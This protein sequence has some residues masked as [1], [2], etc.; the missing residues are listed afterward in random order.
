MMFAFSFDFFSSAYRN[1]EGRKLTYCELEKKIAT[2]TEV[3]CIYRLFAFAIFHSCREIIQIDHGSVEL[4]NRYVFVYVSLSLCWLFFDIHI[5]TY[6]IS[7][8]TGP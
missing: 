7:I 8:Q 1:E 4:R 3:F 6:D 2:D 5:C